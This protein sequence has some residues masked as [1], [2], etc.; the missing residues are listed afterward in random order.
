MVHLLSIKMTENTDNWNWN[1]VLL[2][3]IVQA[4]YL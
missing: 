1:F 2:K 3:K 4:M